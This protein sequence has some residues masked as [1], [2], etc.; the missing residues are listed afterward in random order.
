[1]RTMTASSPSGVFNSLALPGEETDG[2]LRPRSFDEFVGQARV[3]SNLGTWIEAARRR[4]GVLDHVLLSGAPGLGKTTLAHLLADAMGAQLRITSGPALD[5]PGDLVGLLTGLEEGDVLFVDE[6]HRL[7]RTVEEYLYAAMEDRA[8]DVVIDQ[9]PAAR[10]VRLT[11]APFTLVGATTR[12]GLLSQPLRSRFGVVEKLEA[13]PAEEIEVILER[14]AARL[15]CE[16]EAGAV[17]KVAGRARGVP[18]IALRLLRRLRDVADLRADGH[19]TLGVV[20][21]GL[22]MLGIDQ[23]GL[24]PTDRRILT[25]LASQGGGPCGLKT[26]AVAVSEEEDTIELVYEP[27]LIRLGFLRKTPRGREL[28]DAAR[29]HLGLPVAEGRSEGLFEA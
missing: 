24:E 29:H 7:A 8:V 20:D 25:A 13:Y 21:D 23:L 2:P 5:R 14:S 1:M 27:F 19:I 3:V 28:T 10:S 26:I 11:L 9:G 15:G 12:E 22:A 18:R 17:Q 16:L 4:G 6:I